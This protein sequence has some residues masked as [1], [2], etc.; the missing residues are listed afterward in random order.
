MNL[1]VEIYHTL[2]AIP[3]MTFQLILIL[4]SIQCELF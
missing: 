3:L 1:L 2:V 4:K